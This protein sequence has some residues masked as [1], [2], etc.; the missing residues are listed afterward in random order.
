MNLFT[1]VI[2]DEY[3]RSYAQWKCHLI[4]GRPTFTNCA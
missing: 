4:Q 3:L 2:Q 1:E